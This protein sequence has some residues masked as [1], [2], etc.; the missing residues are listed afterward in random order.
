ML[1]NLDGES[2]TRKE[3]TKFEIEDG[4]ILAGMENQVNYSTESVVT[5]SPSHMDTIEE[6]ESESKFQVSEAEL[7]GLNRKQRREK[8]RLMKKA[9]EEKKMQGSLKSSQRTGSGF[10]PPEKM[11]KSDELNY[12]TNNGEEQER[13]ETGYS[14]FGCD[15]LCSTSGSSILMEE[16]S[17]HSDCVVS[18]SSV[19]TKN[20]TCSPQA[21][22]IQGSVSNTMAG[23]KL[24]KNGDTEVEDCRSY[25]GSCTT[26]ACRDCGQTE[27]KIHIS[28]QEETLYQGNLSDDTQNAVDYDFVIKIKNEISDDN[29]GQSTSQSVGTCSDEDSKIKDSKSML[30]DHNKSVEQNSTLKCSSNVDMPVSPI[31]TK[32]N[33]SN[34]VCD[35]GQ[36]CDEI[37]ESE[38]IG[39]LCTS[40]SELES[41]EL[42]ESSEES[43]GSS[44]EDMIQEED[45]GEDQGVYWVVN[46]TSL[47]V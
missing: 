2:E 28:L 34:L 32:R 33:T 24:E 17:T 4:E 27:C 7:Q 19:T 3:D 22:L 6:S 42:T 1:E 8:I 18:D 37:S 14:M 29:Q 20:S 30:S 5:L 11:E 44:D 39:S 36:S 43:D 40:E 45:N 26:P 41:G 38:D 10:E 12:I 47:K 25:V 15:E 21:N 16:T 46:T 31:S 9:F 13:I 35:E 23:S